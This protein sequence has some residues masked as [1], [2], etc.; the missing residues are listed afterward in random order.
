MKKTMDRTMKKQYIQPQAHLTEMKPVKIICLSSGVNN[1]ERG[2][3]YGGID[4]EGEKEP[5][6][7]RR[8]IWDDDETD[9][10]PDPSTAERG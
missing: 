1:R 5:A 4:E 7:R 3:G 2:I 6:A 8:N 9:G 10:L